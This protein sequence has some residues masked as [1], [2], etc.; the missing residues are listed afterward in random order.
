MK[1]KKGSK[2]CNNQENICFLFW[3]IRVR[4]R[5]MPISWHEL[6][7]TNILSLPFLPPS[8]KRILI[9]CGYSLE[10]IKSNHNQKKYTNA[11]VAC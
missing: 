10:I 5:A 2:Y 11:I 8:A 3:K 9:N 4:Q 7:S 1:D 6:L